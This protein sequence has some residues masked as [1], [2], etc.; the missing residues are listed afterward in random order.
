MEVVV[1]VQIHCYQSSQKVIILISIFQVCVSLEPVNANAFLNPAGTD[2][3]SSNPT[4][5]SF[6]IKST[7]ILRAKENVCVR[8]W[9]L[10]RGDFLLGNFTE[11]PKKFNC[12]IT[13]SVKRIT[14]LHPNDLWSY[15]TFA[16][17]IVIFSVKCLI[18]ILTKSNLT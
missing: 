12:R 5:L 18:G 15:G 8:I 13:P 14:R 9:P 7:I 11:C 1:F 6:S 4:K 16:A 2:T 17:V 3:I 10:T